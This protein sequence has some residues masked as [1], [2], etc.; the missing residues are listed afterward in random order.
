MRA[1][2]RPHLSA[3]MTL[4]DM[5]IAI[6]VIGVGLAGVLSALGLATR[7]SADPVVQRQMLAI[8]DELLEEIQLRPY[9]SAANSAPAGCARDSFNDIGDY[10]GYATVNQICTVDGVAI[11]A[12]SGYSVAVTVAPAVLIDVAAARRITVTVSRGNDS[13]TLA[14]WRS[15]HA[16]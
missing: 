14:A 1:N 3:G 5:L 12:L 13:L 2:K 6:V 4:V 9:A 8:A 15:D 10:S 11:A 16:S 7:N